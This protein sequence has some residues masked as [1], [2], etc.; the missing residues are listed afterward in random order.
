MET[1]PSNDPAKAAQGWH[2][3]NLN[4]RSPSEV[5]QELRA[6]G[7]WTTSNGSEVYVIKLE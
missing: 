1:T 4:G 2:L 7:H 5:E 6:A 3:V